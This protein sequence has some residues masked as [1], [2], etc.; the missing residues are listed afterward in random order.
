[1]IKWFKVVLLATCDNQLQRFPVPLILFS[2]LVIDNI[3]N[4]II[5]QDMTSFQWENNNRNIGKY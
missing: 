2:M 5:L 3:L 4:D 1:M